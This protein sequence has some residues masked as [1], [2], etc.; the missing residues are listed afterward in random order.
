[1]ANLLVNDHCQLAPT[2]K[3]DL[4]CCFQIKGMYWTYA[5]ACKI[6]K[7]SRMKTTKL[8]NPKSTTELHVSTQ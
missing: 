7:G 2:F 1:M 6:L 5:Y 3:L 8:K 4:L